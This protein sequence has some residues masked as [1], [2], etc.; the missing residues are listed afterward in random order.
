M[1][2]RLAL[3]ALLAAPLL[4]AT[5]HAQVSQA[6]YDQA[7]D[8]FQSGNYREAETAFRRILPHSTDPAFTRSL[9]WN[10]ARC[11]EERGAPREAIAA[12]EKF[13]A[14]AESAEE[15]ERVRLKLEKVR[16]AVFGTV[17][18]KCAV[19]GTRVALEHPPGQ[20]SAR[21]A[22]P[23]QFAD[24]DAVRVVV[25]AY[26]GEQAPVRQ[27]VN[28]IPGAVADVTL[29]P[30]A[31]PVAD[32]GPWP[33]VTVGTGLALMGTGLAFYASN[34]SNL[35][36]L[37][38]DPTNE[39]LRGAVDRDRNLAIGGYVLGGTALVAGIAWVVHEM[40][41]ENVSTAARIT[42]NGLEVRF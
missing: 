20:I 8:L 32:P 2:K 11:L 41:E 34:Q 25:I 36:E 23:T 13:A 37:R 27:L 21:V 5:A 19:P 24:I 35:D 26:F 12:F 33:W 9:L 42:P 7:L 15:K 39:G 3:F 18:V 28:I 17:A 16:A 14:K 4:S 40:L 22:C 10:I 31:A 38:A 30:L 1:L 29:A 6:E